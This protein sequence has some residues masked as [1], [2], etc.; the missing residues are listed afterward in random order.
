[1]P[2]NARGIIGRL[3]VQKRPLMAEGDRMVRPIYPVFRIYPERWCQCTGVWIWSTSRLTWF[4]PRPRTNSVRRGAQ[5][6]GSKQMENSEV[7][8]TTGGSCWKRSP[9]TKAAQYGEQNIG[10]QCNASRGTTV[11]FETFELFPKFGGLAADKEKQ[12]IARVEG[13]LGLVARVE[14]T[15]RKVWCAPWGGF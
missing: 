7:S 2:H 8:L 6:I 12:D 4:L 3:T 10:L 5:W 15:C 9:R 11:G 14:G 1:M 13:T